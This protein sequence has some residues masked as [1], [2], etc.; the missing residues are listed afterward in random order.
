MS[1]G[2]STFEGAKAAAVEKGLV[3]VLP[4]DNE[5]FVDIDDERSLEEFFSR[6]LILRSTGWVSEDQEAGVVMKA[7]KSRGCHWHAVVTLQHN[8]TPTERVALQLLLGSD[9]IREALSMRAIREKTTPHP[10]L[11]FEVP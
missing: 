2:G 1:R 3:I 9:P 8:V 7:S 4:K 11:F 5:L 6:V 10:T